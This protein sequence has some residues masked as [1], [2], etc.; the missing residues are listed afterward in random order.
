MDLRFE[1]GGEPKFFI[2]SA[3]MMTR[4]LSRWVETV[5]ALRDPEGF[6]QN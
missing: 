1:N 6:S 4:N 3:D 2:G 5:T